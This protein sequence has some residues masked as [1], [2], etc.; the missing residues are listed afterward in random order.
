MRIEH[1]FLGSCKVNNPPLESASVF[2]IL[3][4]DGIQK[5]CT[6]QN[7]PHS[8]YLVRD[9]FCTGEHNF[10]WRSHTAHS[11]VFISISVN[12]I[13]SRSSGKILY[14]GK[15]VC[16]ICSI[17]QVIL[18]MGFGKGWQTLNCIFTFKVFFGES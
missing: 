9:Q 1:N 18:R 6:E 3:T 15:N 16:D 10:F 12:L 11:L 7:F 4:E 2:F 13:K 14:S 5:L 17:G 8:I